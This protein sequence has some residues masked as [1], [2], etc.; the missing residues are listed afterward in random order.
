MEYQKLSKKHILLPS[1]EHA[2]SRAELPFRYKNATS[3]SHSPLYNFSPVDFIQ[4]KLEEDKR[5]NKLEDILRQKWNE[6]M[7]EKQKKKT[8]DLS[9]YEAV[10]SKKKSK[11]PEF[12]L[13]AVSKKPKK[14]K[15]QE[16]THKVPDSID[17]AVVSVLVSKET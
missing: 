5:E 1:L 17:P 11:S 6:G 16:I 9:P 14:I 7:P 2:S 8:F 12:N 3:V 10:L 13:K 15:L 4:L